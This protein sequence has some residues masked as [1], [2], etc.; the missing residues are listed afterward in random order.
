MTFERWRRRVESAT[1][2]WNTVS[3]IHAGGRHPLHRI[4]YRL[5]IYRFRDSGSPTMFG[6]ASLADQDP[7]CYGAYIRGEEVRPRQEALAPTEFRHLEENKLAFAQRCAEAGLACG[8]LLGVIATDASIPSPWTGPIARTAPELDALLRSIGDADVI[9]KL[10]FG[11]SGHGVFGVAI[12]GGVPLSEGG[13]GDAAALF[14]LLASC[15]KP[16]HQPPSLWLIQRRCIPHADLLPLMPGPG[17]GTIR[18]HSFLLA[19]GR[20]ELRWPLLKMPGVGRITDNFQGG[21]NLASIAPV[22]LEGGTLQYCVHRPRNE[23]LIRRFDTHPASGETLSGF[24][25]PEWEA[26]KQLA[27]AGARAFPELPMLSWDVA[28]T[29]A[30]PLLI[31]AN[32]EFGVGIIQIPLRTGI[33]SEFERLF[34]SIAAPRPYRPDRH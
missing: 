11:G 29:P 6:K 30:G 7:S 26:L 9:V 28:V 17:L 27:C 20:V 4:L 14:A 13:V 3:A 1:V 18:I 2:Y 25:V 8:E 33:R 22:N 19:D 16:P 21:T 5:A 32:W 12:R 34:A 31:E 23:S 10:V 15:P 24:R